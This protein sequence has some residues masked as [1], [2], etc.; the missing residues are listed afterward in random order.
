MESDSAESH[1]AIFPNQGAN[2]DFKPFSKQEKNTCSKCV[3]KSAL[4]TLCWKEKYPINAY[5]TIMTTL[6][7]NGSII[8]MLMY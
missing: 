7:Q 1:K 2:A 5:L 8:S 6:L 4:A 3:I